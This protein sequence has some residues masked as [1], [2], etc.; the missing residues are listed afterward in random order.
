MPITENII[1][2]PKKLGFVCHY[3]ARD[4]SGQVF[5]RCFEGDQRP[6]DPEVD[7]C[8]ATFQ[9]KETSFGFWKNFRKCRFGTGSSG[10]NKWLNEM[11]SGR[12][13]ILVS[14]DLV[15][16]SRYVWWVWWVCI[17]DALLRWCCA[18]GVSSILA[19]RR[20]TLPTLR[21]FPK[22]TQLALGMTLL[23]LHYILQV[24]CVLKEDVGGVNRGS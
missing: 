15:F 16:F 18:G 4:R 8:F 11:L 20:E 9:W 23:E 22:D 13:A 3:W 21:Y 17:R 7:I 10:P 2:I 14:K 5:W 12:T 19:F 6:Q 1:E 24:F